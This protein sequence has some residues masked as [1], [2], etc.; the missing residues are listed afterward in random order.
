MQSAYLDDI[1][2]DPVLRRIFKMQP[3]QVMNGLP[4]EPGVPRPRISLPDE[5]MAGVIQEFPG[6]GITPEQMRDEI[7]RASCRERV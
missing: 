4:G 1:M 2:S 3:P 7:G 5:P 6:P